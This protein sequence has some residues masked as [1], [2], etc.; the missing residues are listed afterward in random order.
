MHKR[1]KIIDVV[2][3]PL[4]F[5]VVFLLCALFAVVNLFYPVV[6]YPWGMVVFPVLV[7]FGLIGYFIDERHSDF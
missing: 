4:V 2:F 6:P 5:G 7:F 1:S 3:S